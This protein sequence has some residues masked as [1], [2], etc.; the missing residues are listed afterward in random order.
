MNKIFI[1]PTLLFIPTISTANSL[2]LY[3]NTGFYENNIVAQEKIQYIS[4]PNSVLNDTFIAFTSNNKSIINKIEFKN[5]NFNKTLRENIGKNIVINNENF[6]LKEVYQGFLVVDKE[7]DAKTKET[8]YKISD[9]ET[10]QLETKIPLNEAIFKLHLKDNITDQHINYAYAFNGIQWYGNHKIII[11]RNKDLSYQSKIVIKNDTDI[12]YEDTNVSLMAGEVNINNRQVNQMMR[13]YAADAMAS[14]NMGQASFNSFAGFQ[15]MD[16]PY[17]MTINGHTITEYNFKNYNKHPYEKIYNFSSLTPNNQKVEDVKPN[18]TLTLLRKDNK[19][20]QYPF[21][22]GKVSIYQ[23]NNQD[24]LVLLAHTPIENHSSDQDVDINIGQAFD[25]YM[26]YQSKAT[27]QSVEDIPKSNY[28][29][30]NQTYEFNLEITNN[31][32]E[33][34]I[35]ALPFSNSINIIEPKGFKVAKNSSIN[36]TLEV[37]YRKKTLRKNTL[38]ILRN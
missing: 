28:V 11:N 13:S 27:K 21:V 10:Y 14:S 12:N 5:N 37:S 3:N 30:I 34:V 26:S 8:Y 16:I 33:D 22:K 20:Y 1:I 31:E 2:T 9:I 15:K 38:S 7:G 24:K 36:K 29:Y 4:T 35:V 17:K 32:N 25:V 23:K 6:I 18:M 19:N